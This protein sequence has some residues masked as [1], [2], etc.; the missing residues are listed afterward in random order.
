[1]IYFI[2]IGGAFVKCSIIHNFFSV[3]DS[4]SKDKKTPKD[5]GTNELLYRSEV[6]ILKAIDKNPMANAVELSRIMKITR[7]AVA[8]LS[9][10]LEKKGYIKRY[11]QEGNKKEKFYKLT[12][13]GILAKEGYEKYYLEAN[14]TI[15]DYL[16]MLSSEEVKVIT[17]FLDKL[18]KLLISEFECE[19][20]C[21]HIKKEN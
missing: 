16:K 14:E 19:S 8:Q 15:C 1:M 3:M 20:N 5:Y 21:N 6:N 4:I 12:D 13:K 7:G 10:K 18:T 2:H 9:T 17:N 11:L